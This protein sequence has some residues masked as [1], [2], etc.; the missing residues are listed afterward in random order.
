[1]IGLLVVLSWYKSRHVRGVSGEGW[2]TRSPGGGTAQRA[3][4]SSAL[5]PVKV[6]SIKIE[7]ST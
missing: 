1:M 2:Q 5:S 4:P 3:T 7:S 6:L